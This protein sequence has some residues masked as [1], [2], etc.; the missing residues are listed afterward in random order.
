MA[1]KEEGNKEIIPRWLREKI[2]TRE[3]A[4]K[5]ATTKSTP[6]TKKEG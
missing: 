5:S 2:S 1:K 6:K 4:Q 3:E